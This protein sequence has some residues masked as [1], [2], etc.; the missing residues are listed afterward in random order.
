MKLGFYPKMAANGMRK[1][2]RLYAPYLVTCIMMV[3]VYYILHFL[4]YSGIMDGM[5]GGH[6]ATDMMQM[7][8]YIM[9]LF[10]LLF[11]FYTQATLIKG[12]KKE[13]GLY[14][15]LGMNRFNL[16]RILFF[17]T[18]FTWAVAIFGG[19]IAGIGISK[20]AELGFTKLIAV[21]T[22]YEFS[23]SG[24]SVATTLILFTV[25][26]F[27]IYLNTVRQVRFANP[28]Q[29]INAGKA[30]EKPPKANWVV[31]ILG[32]LFLG[33]GYANTPHRQRR[34]CGQRWWFPLKH[35]APVI[36]LQRSMLCC[37]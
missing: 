23:V 26:F 33:A 12:R 14:S 30:G 4:G 2:G 27:F 10:G 13:F 24:S 20:L 25:I 11:L 15:I 36:S 16:G 29:L 1:N 9:T 32:L 37:S 28:I 18:L 34:D 19:L 6:T 8:T 21:P 35:Q 5:P 3:A 7:G 17:E 22:R 31:G